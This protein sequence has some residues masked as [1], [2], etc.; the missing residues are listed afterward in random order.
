MKIELHDILAISL[1]NDLIATL[2]KI[3]KKEDNFSS[4]DYKDLIEGYTLAREMI[5][6][7]FTYN[8]LNEQRFHSLDTYLNVCI[9]CPSTHTVPLQILQL[10]IKLT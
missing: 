4:N 10:G 1:Y 2:E 7:F 6:H 3:R 9:N 5:E 8:L